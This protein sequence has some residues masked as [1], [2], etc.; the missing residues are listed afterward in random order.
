MSAHTKLYK[1]ENDTK[2][3][4]P[5]SFL[6]LIT[7]IGMSIT[8]FVTFFLSVWVSVVCALAASILWYRCY[9]LFSEDH[10]VKLSIITHL[11]KIEQ[12]VSELK[13]VGN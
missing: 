6:W 11:R 3:A 2:G 4:M 13:R 10:K 7:G 1:L 12:E 9:L 5:K 8:C